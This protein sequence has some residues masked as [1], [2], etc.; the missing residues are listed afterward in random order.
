MLSIGKVGGKDADPQYYTRSV[1]SGREDYYSGE[2]EAQGVWAGQGADQQGLVGLIEEEDFIWALTP[3]AGSERTLLAFDLTFSAPKSVSVLWAVADPEVGRLVRDAHDAAVA[4]A[5]EYVERE[6]AWTRRG[7]GGHRHVQGDGLTIAKFRHRSSRAGDPQL[8]THS[9]VVNETTAEGRGTTLD[10]RALYA[11][12]TTAGY[13]YQ[14]ALRD[15]LTRTLSVGWQ[16]VAGGI[17]EISGVDEGVRRVFSQRRQ[18]ILTE[19]ARVGGRSAKSAQIAALT[20]RRAKEHGVSPTALH[21]DWRTRAQ[22]AGFGRGE[23]AAV[24]GRRPPA[25]PRHPDPETV[26]EDLSA[27]HG[28]T[29]RAS[30]FDRRDAIRQW[31]SAQGEGASVAEVEA[32]ADA[33]IDSPSTVR[34]EDG[35]DR[36]H[37]GG[38]RYSTPDM[39][40]VERRLM[41]T[42]RDRKGQEVTVAPGE[43]AR[44]VIADV[45]SLTEEQRALVH[46]VTRSGDGVQ[47]IRAAAG[48]GKTYALSAARDVWERSG[49]QVY[50]TAL[51][52]R[53]AVELESG[54]GIDATTIARLTNDIG[55]GYG[56]PRGSVLVVDEAGMVGSRA[57]LELA[58]HAAATDSKLLLVGD[59]RQL[60]EIDAGG[61]FRAL[62]KELGATELHQVRRQRHEWDRAAL[63]H[64]RAGRTYEWAKAYEERGRVTARPT[65]VETRGALVEDWWQTARRGGRR[66]DRPSPQ[67]RRRPQRARARPDAGRRPALRGG[68]DDGARHAVRDRRPGPCP[69]QRPAHRHRERHPR[70]GRGARRRP[71]RADRPNRA[72]RR[73][74]DRPAVPRRRARGARLRAHRPR[75]AGRHRTVDRAYVLGSD[76]IYR[77]WGYTALSRQREEARF[78]VVSPSSTERALPALAAAPD[79]TADLDSVLFASRAQGD[80]TRSGPG[81]RGLV[82]PGGCGIADTGRDVREAARRTHAVATPRPAA[83]DERRAEPARCRRASARPRDATRGCPAAA[84]RRRPAARPR[85]PRPPGRRQPVAPRR[86]ATEPARRPR[87]VAPPRGRP[88]RPAGSGARGRGTAGAEPE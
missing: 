76:D 58:E 20:T 49:I 10:G 84:D 69:A 15:Q 66:D 34:L 52:A 13:L 54:A 63:T 71:R 16:P 55:R 7:R 11:H 88:R 46:D 87:G 41:E 45:S 42:A 26:A 60:P 57:L 51:A 12:G 53:A 75:R 74:H 38:A 5:L 62:A 68:A 44:S 59:D 82:A 25:P 35:Y 22:Q 8:H 2:G 39:L 18:E 56:F 43:V 80:R 83:T 78:Y 3:P 4:Q 19:M 64:L 33:W 32:L 28:I 29:E 40:E 47:V 65:I 31:A 37:V 30:T 24:L 6:A 21:E 23:V 48:T 79:V 36:R 85:G 14:A 61:G 50:G 86:R 77:E 67:R 27:A 81:R 70:R 1:A 17:A 9:V 73:G 72:R